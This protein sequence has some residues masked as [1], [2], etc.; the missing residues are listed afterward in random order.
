[1]SGNQISTEKNDKPLGS[2][3]SKES[4]TTA[5]PTWPEKFSCVAKLPGIM[6]AKLKDGS[7]VYKTSN[8][9]Y[10]NN[11][12]KQIFK[13]NKF[14]YENY[15]CNSPEF[16]NIPKEQ[17]KGQSKGQ[18]IKEKIIDAGLDWIAVK[19]E[20]GSTGT[21][22]DNIKL[23]QAWNSGWRP[24]KDVP[25]TYQTALYKQNKGNKPN[26]NVTNVA[27]DEKSLGGGNKTIQG[28]ET[29]KTLEGGKTEVGGEGNKSSGNE[30]PNRNVTTSEVLPSDPSRAYSTLFPT[31]K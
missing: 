27:S 19:K 6:A 11:G 15:D 9:N 12:R 31:N 8:I 29:P 17:S 25:D 22:D 20:F 16:K 3:T 13:D 10:Y 21:K 23:N 5:S 18:T 4:E 26:T 28:G 2:T 14:H 24:G 1:M 30:F 7:T